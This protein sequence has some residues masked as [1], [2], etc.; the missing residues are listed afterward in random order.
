MSAGRE[1]VDLTV[2]REGDEILLLA[3]DVGGFTAP[4]PRGAA[5]APGMVAGALHRLGR[6]VDLVVPAGVAGAVTSDP[7]ERVMAPVAYGAVLYRIDPR[8]AAA[9][10]DDEGPGGTEASGDALAIVASQPGRIWHSPSPGDP[11][12]CGPGDVLEEGAPVCLVEVMKTFSTLPYRRREGL[13]ARAR[14]VRWLTEDGADV[15]PGEPLL[16]IEP[17]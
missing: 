9:A 6:S 8:G 12:F 16:E 3:P 11:P 2:A 7:P 13:P 15:Q 14:V 4:Q 10:I 5:L 17:A 1:R